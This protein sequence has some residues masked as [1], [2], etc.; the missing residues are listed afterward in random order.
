MYNTVHYTTMPAMSPEDDRLETSLIEVETQN[1]VWS[2]ELLGKLDI[3]SL[4]EVTEKMLMSVKKP[5]IAEW[6]DR[7]I[8][9]MEKHEE[10]MLEQ[11]KKI[12]RLQA[13]G[14]ADK[15]KVIKLQTELLARKDDQLSSLQSAIQSTVQE[16]VQT[17]IRTYG[18]VLKNPVSAA[19]SP[20]TF[21]KI[22]KTAIEDEDRTKNLMVFGLAEE[23]G[24][25]LDEKVSEVFLSIGEK[26][27][28]AAVRVG[29]RNEAGTGGDCRPVKVTLSSST[30]VHQILTK[31]RKLRQ[32][33]KFREVYVSPD[34][35]PAEQA[36]RKQLVLKLKELRTA[37]PG[38]YHYIR[39]GQI[40]SKALR[41]D[42]DT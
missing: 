28:A 6:L 1:Q 26:P 16:T 39:S 14:L 15:A 24:E 33:G 36:A 20:A 25:H 41:T 5:L 42:I 38:K 7:A 30:A 27:R 37:Q 8:F 22:V 31:S 23:D 40:A 17:E 34:R 10:A 29:S 19:I 9:V 18:D 32:L 21:K 13:E 3:C 4:K 2:D 12:Q 35:P 11:Q